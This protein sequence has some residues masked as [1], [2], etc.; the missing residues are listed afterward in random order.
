M[1]AGRGSLVRYVIFSGMVSR[2][3]PLI[4]IV[5]HFYEASGNHIV[6]GVKVFILLLI[7]VAVIEGCVEPGTGFS[8]FRVRITQFADKMIG[9]SPLAPRF[10]HIRKDRA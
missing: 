10:S 3:T 5:H 2:S 9:V 1:G 8:G 4:R 6:A 7:N